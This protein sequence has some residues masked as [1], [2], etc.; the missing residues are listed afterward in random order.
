VA[1]EAPEGSIIWEHPDLADSPGAR[2]LRVSLLEVLAIAFEHLEPEHADPN[3][4]A[5]SE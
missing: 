2:A 3:D 1:S 5:E 4:A